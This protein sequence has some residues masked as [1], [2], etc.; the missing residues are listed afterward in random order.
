MM[1]RR[2]CILFR[3]PGA[4]TLACFLGVAPLL[5]L[6]TLLAIATPSALSADT[7]Q[8]KPEAPDRYPRAQKVS[9]LML[10]ADAY[11][12]EERGKAAFGSK[13]KLYEN[14]VLP[15]LL[16]IR[17][18]SQKVIRLERMRV[19][20]HADRA[21]SAAIPATDIPYLRGVKAPRAQ[22]SPIPGRVSV[23]RGKNPLD[24]QEIQDRAFAAPVLPP[25]ETVWGFFYFQARYR[26]NGILY[27]TGLTEAATGNELFFMEVPVSAGL[28]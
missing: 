4:V 1:R 13:A 21:R 3:I 26:E 19:E 28:P 8:F 17:N 14:G 24:A 15:V 5:S 27:I 20:Y 9:G 11:H 10:A 18:D 23:R 22:G 2:Q 12:D 16:V 6:T 25:G 7:S